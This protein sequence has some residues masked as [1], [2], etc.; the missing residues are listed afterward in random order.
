MEFCTKSLKSSNSN[1]VF[2]NTLSIMYFT[3]HIKKCKYKNNNF[4]KMFA[5]TLSVYV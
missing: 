2:Y 5:A 1:N 3:I 4:S